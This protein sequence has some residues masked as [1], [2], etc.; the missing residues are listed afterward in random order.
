MVECF[1]LWCSLR[2]NGKQQQSVLFLTVRG[3]E[4]DSLLKNLA[5][6]DNSAKILF[7]ML[8]QLL[9]VHVNPVDFQAIGREKFNYLVRA[10]SMPCRNF[11]LLLN[12]Q[13]SKCNYGERLEEQLYDRFIAGIK[14][15]TLQRKLLEKKDLKSPDARRM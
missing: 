12:K 10:E 5:F 9:L 8:K 4:M 1:E 11:I 14:N 7:Q 2:Q 3:K 13:A 15:G 6:S